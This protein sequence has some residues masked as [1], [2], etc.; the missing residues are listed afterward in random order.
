MGLTVEQ[1]CKITGLHKR[2]V[3]RLINYGVTDIRVAKRLARKFMLS[4]YRLI[5]EYNTGGFDD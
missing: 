4:D 5:L 1:V 2:Q 3:I